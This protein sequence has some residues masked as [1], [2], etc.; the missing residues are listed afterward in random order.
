MN[1][2]QILPELNVGGV[3]TGTVDFAKY[4]VKLGHKSVVVSHGGTLSKRLISEGSRHYAL[5]VHRK[6]LFTAY[7][8]VQ[9]LVNII[10]DERIDIVHARSRVPAWIAYWACRRT[11]TRFLTTCH[12]YYSKHFFSQV[13]GWGSVV[14]AISEIIAKHMREDFGVPKERIRVIHRGVD[15]ERFGALSRVVQRDTKSVLMIGRITPLKGHAYFLK[16]MARVLEQLPAVKVLIIGDASPKKQIYKD[17][18]V[19]LIKQLGIEHQVELMGNRSD[20]PELL[21]TADCLVLSTITQ[22]AFGRVIIEAQ[23]AGVPVVATRVG[24]VTEIIEHE[25]T[26]LL[27]QPKNTDEMAQAI[28]RILNDAEFSSKLVIKAKEKIKSDYT[29]DRMAELTLTVYRELLS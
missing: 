8:C 1:V 29:L 6:N 11:K 19:L 26:G 22:E 5:P 27:V 12:G 24:G 7:C 15:L 23:A 25:K 28:L 9:K 16:S 4:L 2:L 14:I 21:S 20:I 17:K 10:R 13:M 3:E 18:I